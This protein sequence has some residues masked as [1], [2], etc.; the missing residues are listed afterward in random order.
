MTDLEVLWCR[1]QY[2]FKV[3][4]ETLKGAQLDLGTIDSVQT[5]LF[6]TRGN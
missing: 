5:L 6:H 3:S 1:V 4:G 2:L